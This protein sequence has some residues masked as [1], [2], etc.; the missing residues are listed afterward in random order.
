MRMG[1]PI[2]D[3]IGIT[4]FL[5]INP[6]GGRQLAARRFLASHANSASS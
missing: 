6:L 3:Y 1:T 2:D 5:A 4:V